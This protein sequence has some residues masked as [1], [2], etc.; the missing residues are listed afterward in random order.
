MGWFNKKEDKVVDKKNS[1]QG[2]PEMQDIPEIPELPELPEPP[3]WNKNIDDEVPKLPS[4]P[5]NSLGEKFSQNTIK[6]AISGK[7]EVTRG[8]S[9][10][11]D[12]ARNEVRMMPK[13]L[14]KVREEEEFIPQERYE[15]PHEF[16]EAAMKV[17]KAEPVFIRIDRFQETL[18]ILDST[19]IKIEDMRR[20]LNE[21]K[22]VKEDED[23]TIQEWENEVQSM[24]SKIERIDKDLFSK[25]E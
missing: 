18:E 23:K 12:F 6:E 13:S 17:K 11:D 5:S 14:A 7:G 8:F 19:K 3:Q 4:F 1:F 21:I 24:K 16:R 9:K 20:V 22:K 15:V 2:I 25:V 10:V